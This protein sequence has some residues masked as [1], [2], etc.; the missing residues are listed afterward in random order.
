MSI[1]SACGQVQDVSTN[2]PVSV[3]VYV[4][5]PGERMIMQ[6]SDLVCVVNCLKVSIKTGICLYMCGPGVCVRT[7]PGVIT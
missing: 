4:G 2:I 3:I 6:P 7:R 5:G 1:S